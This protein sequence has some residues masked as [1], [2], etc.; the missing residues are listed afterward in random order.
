[1]HVRPI[2]FIFLLENFAYDTDV[3]QKEGKH[4]LS[5]TIAQ[6]IDDFPKRSILAAS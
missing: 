6:L 2:I 1:M 5:S 4:Y 3:S